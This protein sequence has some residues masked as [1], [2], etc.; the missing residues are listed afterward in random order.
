MCTIERICN[1]CTGFVA[2][3]TYSQV[4]KLIALYIANAYS[5]EREMS[6]SA[7]TRCVAGFF[8]WTCS[9]ACSGGEF[10][11]QH[12]RCIS[13]SL[14][15]DGIADCPAGD[16]ESPDMCGTLFN[17][18]SAPRG[19]EAPFPL[20]PLSIH[21]LIFCSF[22]LFPFSV[23]HSLYLGYFLLL[24][25]PSPFLPARVVPLRFQAGGRRRRPNLG[26]VCSVYFVLS[27]ICIV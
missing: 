17:S 10:S 24:S 13:R 26:L 25:I 5:A 14:V 20:C 23:S 11:C 18:L 21:F 27:V 7:C 9:V 12:G 8:T 3:T 2:T 15:C 1:R 16:D 19:A 4:C 22:L 6:A